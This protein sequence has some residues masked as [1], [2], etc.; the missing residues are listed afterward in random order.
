MSI[1]FQKSAMH[2]NSL[3]QM[4]SSQASSLNGNGI[5]AKPHSQPGDRVSYCKKPGHTRNEIEGACYQCADT[6]C[7]YCIDG[8]KDH[9]LIFFQDSYLK[10]N[11]E[12]VQ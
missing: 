10:N 6:F 7:K 11:Y 12:G 8:H 2:V 3:P 1:N 9:Y 4:Q 5:G